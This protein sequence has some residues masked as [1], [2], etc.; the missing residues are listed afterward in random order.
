MSAQTRETLSAAIAA[1]VADESSS[2][3]EVPS[4]WVLIAETTSLEEIDRSTSSCFTDVSPHVSQ[5]TVRGLVESVRDNLARW[6][7][8]D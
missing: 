5:F 3:A 1:H 6:G 4:A 2:G 7:T 8:G